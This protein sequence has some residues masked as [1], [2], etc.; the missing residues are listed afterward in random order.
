ML[1]YSGGAS[2]SL[3]NLQTYAVVDLDANLEAFAGDPQSSTAGE[4]AVEGSSTSS[5]SGHNNDPGG[6]CFPSR[7][8]QTTCIK[9]CGLCSLTFAIAHV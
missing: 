6:G 1:N 7:A 8:K 4:D 9:Y 3:P 5:G 2:I